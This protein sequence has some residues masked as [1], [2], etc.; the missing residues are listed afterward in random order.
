[1]KIKVFS[2]LAISSLSIAIFFLSCAKNNE[3]DLIKIANCDTTAISFADNLKPEIDQK[4]NTSGC[5]NASSQAAG[6]NL[7]G[8]ANVK[9]ALGNGNFLGAINHAIGYS[10]MPKGGSKLDACY[11]LQL[12]T[13]INRGANNN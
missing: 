3:Q 9:N 11:I 6:I 7:E 8:Y 2:F 10:A 12:E 4:C 13:W 1:M 5:H